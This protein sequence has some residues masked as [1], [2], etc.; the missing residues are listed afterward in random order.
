MASAAPLLPAAAGIAV[1]ALPVC[2]ALFEHGRF[3]P[4]QSLVTAQALSWLALGLPAYGFNKVAAS[5]LYALGRQG[6]PLIIISCQ[7][8]LNALL[9]YAFMD[10]MGAGGLMLTG[11]GWGHGVGMCQWGTY[12]M[13][14]RGRSADLEPEPRL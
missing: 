14:L 8:A 13:A 4:E 6:A 10:S 5:S 1:T 9:C 3:T 7:L 11:R 2:R 12:V